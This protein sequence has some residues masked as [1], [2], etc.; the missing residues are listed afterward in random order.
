M[1]VYLASKY[2]RRLELKEHAKTFRAAGH[3]V[4]CR[5]L[6]GS[7]DVYG[8]DPDNDKKRWALEDLADIFNSRVIICFSESP[9]ETDL[10]KGGRHIE[11]GLAMAWNKTIILI[12]PKENMFHYL[13][14]VFQCDDIQQALA[15]LRRMKPEKK[16]KYGKSVSDLTPMEKEHRKQAISYKGKRSL[17]YEE[18]RRKIKDGVKKKA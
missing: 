7:H 10:G 5:W 6:D 13:D 12:G 8:S 18:E 9:G 14:N 15:E 1:K 4:I 3:E 2:S 11:M 16:K 17:W